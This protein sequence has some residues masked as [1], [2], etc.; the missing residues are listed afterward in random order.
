MQLLQEQKDK[1]EEELNAKETENYTL[2]KNSEALLA[3]LNEQANQNS[4]LRKDIETLQIQNESM[5]INLKA[6]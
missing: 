2:R 1:L 3:K 5:Q 4:S 6:M